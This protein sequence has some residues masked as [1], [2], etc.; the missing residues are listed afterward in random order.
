[1]KAWVLRQ[2]SLVRSLDV[3]VEAGLVLL[4]HLPTFQ[5]STIV[6]LM[7][8]ML[9]RWLNSSPFLFVPLLGRKLVRLLMVLLFVGA[10]RSSLGIRARGRRGAGLR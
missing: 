9:L 10:G 8:F 6:G 3:A 4:L 2:R 7:E 5:S 1:M